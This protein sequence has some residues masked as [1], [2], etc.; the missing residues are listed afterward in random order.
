MDVTVVCSG[1]IH[2]VLRQ[3]QGYG[4]QCVACIGENISDIWYSADTKVSREKVQTYFI[5]R[6]EIGHADTDRHFSLP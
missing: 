1:P 5:A 3:Q 2:G 6:T 4:D